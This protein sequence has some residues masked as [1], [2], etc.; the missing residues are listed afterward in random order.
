[1]RPSLLRKFIT[2]A[3]IAGTFCWITSFPAAATDATDNTTASDDWQFKAEAYG[4]LP[5]IEG[6]LPTGDDIEIPLDKI[7]DNLDFTFMGAVKASRGK[8]SIVSDVVY[9]KLSTDEAG[10]TTLPVGRLDLPTRIDIGVEMKAW[11]VNLVGAYSVHR[12]EK[13]DVQV[14][15]GARYFSLDLGAEL[16]ASIVPGETIVDG[17]DDVLDGIVGLR[18]AAELSDK[19]WLNYRF[20]IGAGGSDLT[21]NAAAQLGRRFD[22]GSLVLGYRYLHHDFDSDFKLLKDLDIHGPLIGAAWEF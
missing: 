13:V 11:I 6:T 21:W 22:W 12:T 1:M 8:W 14:L 2:K 3:F 9:L 16:D 4:W 20:D 10:K 5:D 17:R 7:L 15:A 19:W 18:G